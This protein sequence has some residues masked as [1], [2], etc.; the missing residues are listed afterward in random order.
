MEKD[1]GDKAFYKNIF[2]LLDINLYFCIDYYFII[3]NKFQMEDIQNVTTPPPKETSNSVKEPSRS[4]YPSF[5]LTASEHFALK[6]YSE[7]GYSHFHSKDTIAQIFETNYDSIKTKLSTALQYQLLELK[8]GTG[9]KVTPLFLKLYRP[10][11]ENERRDG[12]LDALKSPALYEQVLSEYNGHHFPTETGL[13]TILF[14]RYGLNERASHRATQ[15]LLNNLREHGLIG[16]DGIL[17]FTNVMLDNNNTIEFIEHKDIKDNNVRALPP[18]TNADILNAEYLEI[19]IP[20][21][22]GKAYLRVPEGA[23]AEDYQKIAR[24]VEAYK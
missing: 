2:C 9:Y 6:I 16:T 18:S 13:S 21:S 23:S 14:R 3:V 19:P 7:L 5:T 24:I 20:I 1:A 8:H 10:H 4:V 15:V 22:S 12:V 11:D 17:S